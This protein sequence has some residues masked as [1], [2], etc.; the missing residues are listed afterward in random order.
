MPHLLSVEKLVVKRCSIWRWLTVGSLLRK[1]GAGDGDRTRNIQLGNQ[2]FR[3]F[4]FNTYKIAEKKCSCMRCIPCMHCLICV[5][6]GD[7]WGTVLRY[8]SLP[9]LSFEPFPIREFAQ[10]NAPHLRVF[11]CHTT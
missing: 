9:V 1:N 3:S 2:N 8:D 5:S 4:I 10:V 11:E 6:P 7:V